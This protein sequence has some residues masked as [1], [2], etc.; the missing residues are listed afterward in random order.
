MKIPEYL[1]PR[2]FGFV[3]LLALLFL[4]LIAYRGIQ[5]RRLDQKAVEVEK[6][7]VQVAVQT[8]DS[9]G[10][11]AD[12]ADAAKGMPRAVTAMIVV[13]C[14]MTQSSFER[15]AMSSRRWLNA[16]V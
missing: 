11:V 1:N 16:P 12:A 14:L 2:K 10:A 15:L 9:A 5:Q 7:A 13:T 3:V 6:V 8:R 4:G